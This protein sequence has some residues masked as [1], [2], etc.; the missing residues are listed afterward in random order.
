LD[1]VQSGFVILG[2]VLSSVI[3]FTAGNEMYKIVNIDY[4]DAKQALE[5]IIDKAQQMQKAVAVAVTDSHGELIAF[6]RMD[7]VP[8]PSI[9]IAMNKACTAARTGKPT[10][11][12]GDRV[13]HPEKGHDISYYG[14][15]R[16]VGWGGGIPVRI[17]GKIAGGIGVSGLSSAEDTALANLGADL[18]A[19]SS[20]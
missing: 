20:G 3:L 11:E 5:R 18:I 13:K 6:A 2:I 16:F 7:E 14:D 1:P 8:L 19:R 17:N 15:S 12:I 4:S 9:M 10:E